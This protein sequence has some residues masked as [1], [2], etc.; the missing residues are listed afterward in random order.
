MP[1]RPSS[2]RVCPVR[3]IE[4][5]GESVVAGW[6]GPKNPRGTAGLSV[7]MW[8]TAAAAASGSETRGHPGRAFQVTPPEGG[9]HD[10]VLEISGREPPGV[11]TGAEAFWETT[12]S[13]WSRQVPD[14]FSSVDAPADHFAERH[15]RRADPAPAP[16]VPSHWRSVSDSPRESAFPPRPGG[17]SSVSWLISAGP[18]THH[19][20]A[21]G[22]GRPALGSTRKIPVE[23]QIRRQ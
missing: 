16:G 3:A 7:R 19:Q 13:A 18:R 23:E 1:G 12:E 15:Y 6:D 14:L 22:L 9:H 20:E 21:P 10:L 5:P 17:L 8:W 2:R 11:P 4:N